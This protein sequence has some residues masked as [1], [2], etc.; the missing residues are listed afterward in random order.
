MAGPKRSY[1]WILAR[2]KRLD[3]NTLANLVAQAKAWGFETDRLIFVRH[4]LTQE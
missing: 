1:L 4:D 3:E 2:E